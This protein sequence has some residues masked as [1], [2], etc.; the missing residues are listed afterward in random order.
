MCNHIKNREKVATNVN[1][2]CII[3]F[4]HNV[5]SKYKYLWIMPYPPLTSLTYLTGYLEKIGNQLATKYVC[6]YIACATRH[7]HV[8]NCQNI[9]NSWDN[10]LT[11]D[12]VHTEF[13][14]FLLL[15]YF[16]M[17]ARIKMCYTV[18]IGMCCIR[19]CSY[20]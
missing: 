20:F 15:S 14:L 11:N 12:R 3:S 1:D 8:T 2:H 5:I 19:L 17:L 4:N 16:G 18:I 7:W 9:N 6:V 10:L 13:R